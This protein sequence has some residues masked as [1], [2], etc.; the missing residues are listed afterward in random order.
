MNKQ[1]FDEPLPNDLTQAIDAISALE[2]PADSVLRVINR[3]VDLSAPPSTATS[4]LRYKYLMWTCCVVAILS[5]LVF[6]FLKSRLDVLP[7]WE[8]PA[9]RFLVVGL[10]T[11]GFGMLAW[12]FGQRVIGAIEK[13]TATNVRWFANFA[14]LVVFG[15]VLSN[16][17]GTPGNLY[18]QMQE[19]LAKLKTVQYVVTMSDFKTGKPLGPQ[20]RVYMQEPNLM[21]METGA[22]GISQLE[23]IIDL[24][25]KSS[26]E[27]DVEAKTAEILPLYQI[28][29]MKNNWNQ[30][31][32]DLQRLD[33]ESK[34][35]GDSTIDGRLCADFEVETEGVVS[36]VSIDKETKLPV[37]ITTTVGEEQP[38]T[39]LIDQFVFDEPLDPKLFSLEPPAGYATTVVARKEAVDDSAMEL[40]PGKNFGAANF[41]MSLEQVINALGQPDKISDFE[42]MFFMD[43]LD[44]D[45]LPEDIAPDELLKTYQV[46]KL[47]Y[48]SRGFELTVDKKQGLI[49]VHCFG[50]AGGGRVFQGQIAGG[51]K[52]GDS[53]DE[54]R[55]LLGEPF[56]KGDIDKGESADDSTYK[57][58]NNSIIQFKFDDSKLILVIARKK[59]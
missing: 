1:N 22:D 6:Y 19:T 16:L 8:H 13:R 14:T 39:G 38:I 32:N 45:A 20:S 9:V 30:A 17:L 51:V 52:M 40:L 58:A 34:L 59:D 48:R 10:V 3:S 23:I 42:D 57:A 26:L 43:E 15:L 24:N 54:V 46:R 11:L 21:R 2:A 31:I 37:Q 12:S 50:W 36:V 55:N 28:E 41:G 33:S 35:I 44:P 18:A 29:E 56:R 49:A 4:P 53:P 5:P 27:I 47:N 7:G 25:Q